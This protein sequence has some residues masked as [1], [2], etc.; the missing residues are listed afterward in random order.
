MAKKELKSLV[1]TNLKKA[2]EN[3]EHLI[4]DHKDLLNE[5]IILNGR[6]T[7]TS[8]YFNLNIAEKQSI[9]I[10]LSKI[11]K[12]LIELIDRWEPKKGIKESKKSYQDLRDHLR[13][14]PWIELMNKGLLHLYG[15]KDK[16][17]SMDIEDDYPQIAKIVG[18]YISKSGIRHHRDMQISIVNSERV[19]I[20]HDWQYMIGGYA[21][22]K[23]VISGIDFYDTVF[24]YPF[25]V[26]SWIDKTSN[27]AVEFEF[28][29][30]IALFSNLDTSRIVVEMHNEK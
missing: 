25:G 11:R 9:D 22:H 6:F 1:A 8:K 2:F 23:D 15:I 3:F 24:G 29:E 16:L 30:N 17:E 12:S 21:E 20:F 18:D 14:F 10:E 7:D 26:V 27:H 13:Q 19:F 4:G 5:L 28:R